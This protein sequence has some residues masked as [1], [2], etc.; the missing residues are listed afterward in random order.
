VLVVLAAYAGWEGV[1]SRQTAA[2]QWSVGL[3]AVAVA[4]L[5][6]AAGRGRQ[7][8]TSGAWLAGTA[9]AVRDGRAA[10]RYAAGVAVWALL[11]L[12]VIGWD[13]NSFV[14]QTHDLPTLSYLVGRVTRFA[15]GRAL[16]FAGWLAVGVGL[17]VDCR[18]SRPRRG[19]E[20]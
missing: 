19:T 6:V 11:I 2:A 20:P 3:T 1:Q 16:F 7:A 13:L 9:R 10:P 17:A 18:T 15:W 12:A 5:A 4:A 8:T 14:H